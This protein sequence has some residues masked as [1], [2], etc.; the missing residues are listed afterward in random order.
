MAFLLWLRSSV[1]LEREGEAARVLPVPWNPREKV[2][3][4]KV[5]TG[6]ESG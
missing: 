2:Y 6:W 5:E 1:S 3:R 4:D